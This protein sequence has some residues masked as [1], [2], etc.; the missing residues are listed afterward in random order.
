[1]ASGQSNQSEKLLHVRCDSNSKTIRPEMLFTDVFV[2]FLSEIV[3]HTG[4]PVSLEVPVLIMLL[5]VTT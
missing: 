3:R 2:D 4:N 5:L 1:M